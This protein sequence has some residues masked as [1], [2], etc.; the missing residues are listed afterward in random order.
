[1]SAEN[2]QRGVANAKERIEGLE[3]ATLT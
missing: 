2:R 3:P 1:M